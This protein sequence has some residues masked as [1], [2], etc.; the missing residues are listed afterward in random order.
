MRTI[1]LIVTILSVP[2]AALAQ[3]GKYSAPVI[4]DNIQLR[5]GASWQFPQTGKLKKG[6]QVIVHHEDGLWVAI[7]PPPGTVSWVNHRFLGEFDPNVGGKQNA[8]IMA[9]NVE[10]RLGQE[11]PGPLAVTQV[12]LPRG[13]WVEV[14]G[15]KFQD[16]MTT[17]YPITPPEGEFRWLPKESLGA[18]SAIA[19]PPVFVKSGVTPPAAPPGS[20][21]ATGTLTSAAPKAA[22]AIQ[23]PIWDKAEQAER[24]GDYA[25]AEKF[26]TMVYQQ[27]QQQRNSDPEQ[28]IVCY[29]RITRC[30][31]RLKQNGAPNR[32]SLPLPLATS[33]PGNKPSSLLPPTGIS[34]SGASGTAWP[35]T[36]TI[37]NSQ[38]T[39][40]PGN[41]RRTVF[42]IDGKQAYALENPPG[43]VIFYVTAAPGQ[44]L[45]PYVNRRVELFG[46]VIPRGDVRGAQY[47]VVTQINPK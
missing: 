6:E 20:D 19:P 41:L 24:A 11:Q 29:N 12:K 4:L 25:S 37:P 8:L 31:D 27:L 47:M 5:A 23:N 42:E 44:N 9:D 30:Q 2:A 10:V 1:G 18:P 45:D 22:T 26:Y 3:S 13:T 38:Q 21:L 43:Q 33:N 15:P 34:A 40:G 14:V 7:T 28:L 36:S 35:A 39:S 16:G 32:S 46:A 17:W